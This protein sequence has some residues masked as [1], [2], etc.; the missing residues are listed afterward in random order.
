M[1]SAYR[2]YHSTETAV[3][4]FKLSVTFSKHW[5]VAI[6]QLLRWSTYLP[7]LTVSTT[8][9]YFVSSYGIHSTV[10]NWFTS[11]VQQRVQYDRFRGRSSSGP[12]IQ[13]CYAGCRKVRALDQ[14]FFF[15]ILLTWRDSVGRYT[16]SAYASLRRLYADLRV[17]PFWG[18][19]DSH[20]PYECISSLTRSCD[21]SRHTTYYHAFSRRIAGYICRVLSLSDCKYSLN[22]LSQTRIDWVGRYR[23]RWTFK[24]SCRH[25]G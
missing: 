4:Y 18:N 7:R 25:V 10:L 16:W 24:L 22:P 14:S 19:W 3:A 5:I 11:Y 6:W 20:G 8:W 23:I 12:P 17:L 1:Q 9:W 15:Y 13:R 21:I 2:S